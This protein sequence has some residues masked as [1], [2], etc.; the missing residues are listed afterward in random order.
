VIG[1]LDVC[2]TQVDAFSADD[3]TLLEAL[4][5]QIAVAVE[6]ARLFERLGEERATL[7]A[8]INGTGDAIIVTDP[9]DR[10]LFFNLAA[11]RVFL[12]AGR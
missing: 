1:V 7:E 4:A 8:I 5:A 10:I 9:T 6:N 12:G 2:S 11:R 3:Q